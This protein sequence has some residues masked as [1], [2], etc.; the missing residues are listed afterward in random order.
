VGCAAVWVGGV[1]ALC[2]LAV[3]R[4]P[5]WAAAVPRMS[6]VAGWAVLGVALS[7]A[8]TALT[9]V[10]SWSDLQTG[11]GVV[12]LLKVAALGALVAIGAGQRRAARSTTVGSRRALVARSVVE[13][14]VM[15][16]TFALAAGL[17]DTPPPV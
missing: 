1:A 2:W 15:V 16:L 14:L 10:Q 6:R 7:G 11:Y 8:T 13:L 12:V 9:R 3:L 17:A 5:G 4:R